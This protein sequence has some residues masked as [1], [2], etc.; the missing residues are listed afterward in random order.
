M[1]TKSRYKLVYSVDKEVKELE[2]VVELSL[3]DGLHQP[4]Q[5]IYC[6]NAFINGKACDEDLSSCVNAK[7]AAE[8]IGYKEKAKIVEHCKTEGKKLKI[9]SEEV[10]L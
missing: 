5:N 4:Q 2:V 6:G 9:K 10:K 8:Q 1:E 7:F 3:V